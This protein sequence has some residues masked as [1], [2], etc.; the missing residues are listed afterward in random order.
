M[1]ASSKWIAEII[2]SPSD[3]WGNQ[4]PFRSLRPQPCGRAA[5]QRAR[6]RALDLFDSRSHAQTASFGSRRS[7]DEQSDL[8]EAKLPA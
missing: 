8:M 2:P 6:N 7:T 4:F 1:P 5:A 3:Q